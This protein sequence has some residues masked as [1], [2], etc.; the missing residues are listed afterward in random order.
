MAAANNKISEMDLK[1]EVDPS[2]RWE[3]EKHSQLLSMFPGLCPDYLL[4]D[5]VRA[6]NK[7]NTAD[8]E[9][10]DA[11][12]RIEVEG[13]LAKSPEERR[14]LPTRSQWETKRKEKEELEKWTGNVSVDDML[15]LYSDDPAGYFGNPDR[16]PESELYKQHAVEG[17]K[18]E[19]RFVSFS[20]SPLMSHFNQFCSGI[21]LTGRS[22]KSSEK[23][24]LSTSLP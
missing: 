13:I 16:K 4:N 18:N 24:S 15:I 1:A 12:F 19:F 23:Q 17:L 3:L 2:V 10:L 14:L 21:N 7:P 8:V 11:R 5:V 20:S 9:Q 22:K 6:I